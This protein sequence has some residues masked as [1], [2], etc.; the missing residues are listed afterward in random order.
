ML[1]GQVIHATKRTSYPVIA[2]PVPCFVLLNPVSPN[3]SL[4]KT[5]SLLFAA[6]KLSGI[7]PRVCWFYSAFV[8][9][10]VAI[11]REETN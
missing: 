8:S 9:V 6:A 4:L 11:T 3:I 7:P 1:F 10:V 2:C 5:S